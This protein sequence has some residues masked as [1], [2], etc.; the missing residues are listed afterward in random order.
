MS[1]T[2]SNRRETL[3][4]RLAKRRRLRDKK[5]FSKSSIDESEITSI[6]LSPTITIT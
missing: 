1:N 5:F 2:L 6:N 4:D 3:E